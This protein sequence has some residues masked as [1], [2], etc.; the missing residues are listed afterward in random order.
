M[1]PKIL[2]NVSELTKE[3]IGD[4]YFLSLSNIETRKMHVGLMGKRE[5][6]TPVGPSVH[7][8]KP[9]C[10]CWYSGLISLAHALDPGVI[11]P[12]AEE[13]VSYLVQNFERAK[14]A[15]AA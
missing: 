12:P 1:Q 8:L 14:T 7:D 15:I 10:T 4:L 9:D 2:T 3:G 11:L 6:P 5:G 13:V